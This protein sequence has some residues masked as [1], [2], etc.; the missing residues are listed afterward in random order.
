MAKERKGIM[1]KVFLGETLLP[2]TPS[3]ITFK[4]N[5]KNKTMNLMDDGEINQ[6][7]PAGLTDIKLEFLLP[8]KPYPFIQ[9]TYMQHGILIYYPSYFLDILEKKKIEQK[10]FQLIVTR[11]YAGN[12]KA[13]DTNLTVALEDYQFTDDA[14]NGT[15]VEVSVQLKQYVPYSTKS[16][17]IEK[18]ENG[19]TIIE[20]DKKRNSN[21][22]IPNTYTVKKG[23]T[24]WAIAKKLLGDGAKCWNLAKLNLIS[25]P[26]LIY[27]GQVLKI[28][29]VAATTAPKS[30]RKSN[31][32]NDKS[33]NNKITVK[34]PI[35]NIA[36]LGVTIGASASSSKTPSLT[37][38]SGYAS[39][40]P[41]KGRGNYEQVM[42]QKW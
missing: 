30:N 12:Q 3:K 22:K 28:Q 42:Y 38:S 34:S 18:K 25:N 29:D 35:P 32:S 21:K 41:R 37:G 23:D 19:N 39:N 20:E 17:K 2:I 31:S 36:V 40:P 24:L 14:N 26:N 15:D 9:E 16:I 6:I 5:G 1:Y 8:S 13:Y 33:S 11:I 7:K 10:P 4:I 27:P